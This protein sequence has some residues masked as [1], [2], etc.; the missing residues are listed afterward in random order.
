[1]PHADMVIADMREATR[2]NALRLVADLRASIGGRDC[3]IL[4]L[5]AA[6]ADD[7]AAT[8][9]D[10]GASDILF[11][12]ISAEEM[13]LRLS[14]QLDQKRATDQLRDQIRGSLQAAVTDPLTGLYNRRYALSYL[15]CMLTEDGNANR[16][17]AVM[18]ADLDHFK[19]I[20]DTYGHAAGDTVL[21][22]VASTLSDKLRAQDLVARIG[23][24][25]FLII[26]P[27]TSR[28]EAH[29]I[30]KTLC[31]AVQTL[32]LQLAETGMPIAVTI[33]IGVTLASAA[34]QNGVNS[35]SQTRT[36]LELAGSRALHLQ[37]GRAKHSHP[38]HPQRRLSRPG[39]YLCRLSTMA[40]SR[41]A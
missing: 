4:P 26:V 21:A 8:L 30:A 32:E 14:I 12:G 11:D 39:P 34:P 24:E 29:R 13:A 38:E 31:Q 15:K 40:S 6:D 23:G 17:F 35:E 1:M 41:S 28:G 18:V 20:N 16:N 7:L 3:P 10:M 27:D 19:S 25:E 9:L 37:G 22:Q 5:L 33:S 36:L 2:E